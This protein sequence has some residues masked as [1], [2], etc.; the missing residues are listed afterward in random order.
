MKVLLNERSIRISDSKISDVIFAEIYMAL[1][2]DSCFP[3]RS[4][5][6]FAETI[7]S[8]WME[9]I[10]RFLVHGSEARLRFMDGDFQ[11]TVSNQDKKTADFVFFENGKII[12]QIRA[13]VCEFSQTVLD[14]SRI[15]SRA[16]HEL[17]KNRKMDE[18]FLRNQNALMWALRNSCVR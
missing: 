13:D 11:V 8:W 6:D 18:T 1:G 7:L 5:D 12:N 10:T 17:S 2:P 9:E 16:I 3:E 4:W 14:S 15:L